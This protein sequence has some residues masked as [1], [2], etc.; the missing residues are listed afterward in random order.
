MSEFD[1]SVTGVAGTLA[2]ILLIVLLAEH[3]ILRVAGR[4]QLRSRR[5]ALLIAIVPLIIVF[6]LVAVLRLTQI[7]FTHHP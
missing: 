4:P 7:E 5:S 2:I 6:V 3:E 1:P